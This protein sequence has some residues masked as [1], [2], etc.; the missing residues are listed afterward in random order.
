MNDLIGFYRDG[1]P[2]SSGNTLDEILHWDDETWEG[3][4]DFIQW[5][6]PLME[7]SKFNPDA[8]LLDDNTIK[9]FKSSL[10]IRLN[11]SRVLHRAKHFFGLYS[12]EKPVWF[13]PKDHNMLRIT[14]LLT[15]LVLI[16]QTNDASYLYNW[17]DRMDYLYPD[18]VPEVTWDFWQNAYW[19][20]MDYMAVFNNI[21][22]EE[23]DEIL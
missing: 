19:G 1:L 9:V 12:Y 10:T 2:N 4:H 23:D 16:D 11:I 7:P 6:F 8:P 3:C 13:E 22:N 20:T 21:P 18:C 17:L 5:I 15:F 14:R